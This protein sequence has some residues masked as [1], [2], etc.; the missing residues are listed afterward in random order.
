MIEFRDVYK[1]FGPKVVLSG[2]G[3]SVAQGEIVFVIGR[4]GVGKSVLLKHL[5][6]LI[7]PD[8]GDVRFNGKVVSGASE[9]IKFETRKSCGLVFQVPALLDSLT[10]FE[11]IGFGLKAHQMVDGD[12]QLEERAIEALTKVHVP[13]SV[14]YRYPHELS[15]SVQ[16]RVSI[17]R[18]IALEPQA[19]L[20]DEPTTSLDPVN[21]HRINDLIQQ[22]SRDLGTACIVVSHDMQCALEI[23]DRIVLLDQGKVVLDAPPAGFLSSEIKLVSQFMVEATERGFGHG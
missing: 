19:L 11:N 3:F 21:T 5:V 16:K 17:A 12:E 23:A 14:L 10:V 15:Y 7:D 9:Q 13:E 4:S 18:A 2:V 1:S 8:K 22:L 6:G 20:F